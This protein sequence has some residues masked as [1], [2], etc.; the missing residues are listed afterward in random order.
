MSTT[1]SQSTVEG[2]ALFRRVDRNMQVARGQ[3]TSAALGT[4]AEPWRTT[5]SHGQQREAQR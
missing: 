4:A 5:D 1:F 3:G 2:A